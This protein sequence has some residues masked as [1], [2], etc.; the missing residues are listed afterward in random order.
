LRNRAIFIIKES[1]MKDSQLEKMSIEEL[2]DLKG[3]IDAMIGNKKDRKRTELKER[4]AAMAKEE[5]Y[6]I[7]DLYNGGGGRKPGRGVRAGGSAAK[8]QH[9]DNPAMTWS[10]RGRKP[11]WVKELG[12]DIE[13]YRV[14]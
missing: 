11:N 8:F 14:G 5:G 10:G 2:V 9:P 3:R 12:G 4:L 7:S 1:R 6:S 13:R